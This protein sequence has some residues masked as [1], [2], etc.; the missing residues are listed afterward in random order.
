MNIPEPP[1]KSSILVSQ[2]D[3]GIVIS[4]KKQ[5]GG[6]VRVMKILFAGVP[7]CIIIPGGIFTLSQFVANGGP[8]WVVL[9]MLAFAIPILGIP[10]RVLYLLVRPEVPESVTLL[11]DRIRYDTGT[12]VAVGLDRSMLVNFNNLSLYSKMFQRHEVD[13]FSRDDSPRFV[14]EGSGLRRQLRIIDGSGRS[15]VVGDTLRI[16]NADRLWLANVLNMWNKSEE[17]EESK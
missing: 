16:R 3:D 1:T 7:L 11:R 2:T 15:R 4:W 6:L 10:A 9:V 17:W 14:L 12:A 8:V 5:F 13:Y